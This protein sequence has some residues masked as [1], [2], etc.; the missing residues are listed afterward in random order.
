MKV[1]K[2]QGCHNE[3]GK[4]GRGY[5]AT[6]CGACKKARKQGI[7]IYHIYKKQVCEL[8]GF[9]PYIPQQLDVHHI[10]GDRQNNDSNNLKTLCANCHRL[11]HY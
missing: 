4:N 2:T 1:C 8:C 9:V 7:P 3:T 11:M 10:D 5:Y 6:Y